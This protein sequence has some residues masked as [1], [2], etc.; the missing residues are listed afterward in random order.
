MNGGLIRKGATQFQAVVAR[1]MGNA[2]QLMARLT[3]KAID[4]GMTKRVAEMREFFQLQATKAAEGL[5]QGATAVKERGVVSLD[6]EKKVEAARGAI[7]DMIT[8][9]AKEHNIK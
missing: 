8:K 7:K 2:N 3:E 5:K 6:A 1:E 4:P 9:V